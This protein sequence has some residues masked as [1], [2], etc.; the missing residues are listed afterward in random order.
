M[1]IKKVVIDIQ[2]YTG[3]N[4]QLLETLRTEGSQKSFIKTFCYNNK[5]TNKFTKRLPKLSDK[6]MYFTLLI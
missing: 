5:V 6:E 2:N 4:S 3:L 1:F